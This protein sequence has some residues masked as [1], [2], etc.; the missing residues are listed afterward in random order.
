L[1]SHSENRGLEGLY[2]FRFGGENIEGT[3]YIDNCKC[4]S[5]EQI[6]TTPF[7]QNM[8]TIKDVKDGTLECDVCGK[9]YASLR[10]LKR[11][12]TTHSDQ[13]P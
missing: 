10:S 11:Y 9:L 5:L 1:Q 4:S 3:A 7:T 2:T 12:G 13:K 8:R 6:E